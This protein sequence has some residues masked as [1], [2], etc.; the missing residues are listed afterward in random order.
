MYRRSLIIA[1]AAA[2]ACPDLARSQAPLVLSADGALPLLLT[3]PH[4]GDA[5]LE[6]VPPRTRGTTVRDLGT[7]RLAEQLAD[8]L[9]R[10]FNARPRMVIA[11]FSRR[12]LDVNRNEREAMEVPEALPVYQ[13]YH[14]EIRRHLAEMRAAFPKGALL[15]DIHGQGQVPGT[16]FR[17]TQNGL[18]VR[19]LLA[20][21]GAAAHQGE[22]SLLGGLA[23]QGYTV[24]PGVDAASQAEDSRF[25]GGYT[26]QTY[27]SHR[28]NGVDAIQLEF[29]SAQRASPELAPHLAQAVGAFLTQWG[30]WPG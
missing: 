19:A 28:P 6:G 4:D 7:R 18:T 1:S 5:P 17:G 21:H 25:D 30:Y 20:R 12:F 15:L 24:H 22:Q 27:G 29:G 23:A 16:L 8:H 13:T 2:V 3:V 11:R 10:R 14:G 26:V 9:E